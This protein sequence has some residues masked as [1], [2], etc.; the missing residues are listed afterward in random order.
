M[1]AKYTPLKLLIWRLYWRSHTKSNWSPWP[2]SYLNIKSTSTSANKVQKWQIV[3]TVPSICIRQSIVFNWIFATIPSITIFCWMPSM[4]QILLFHC[5]TK[6]LEL[7]IWNAII[8]Y[9]N[10]PLVTAKT[11][12]EKSRLPAW[13]VLLLSIISLESKNCLKTCKLLT[14]LVD[15]QSY[16]SEVCQFWLEN[17]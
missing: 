4:P 15:Q 16:C 9:V 8:Q 10:S 7:F 2:H 11:F 5:K 1:P 3:Q 17:V 12:L 6:S 13:K 14:T